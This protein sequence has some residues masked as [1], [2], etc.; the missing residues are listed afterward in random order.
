MVKLQINLEMA[1]VSFKIF[2]LIKISCRINHLS[3]INFVFLL[4]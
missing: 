2:Y 3:H 4:V 1:N